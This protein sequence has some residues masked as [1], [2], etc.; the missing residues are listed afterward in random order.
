MKSAIVDAA[1]VGS[2]AALAL[3]V[4]SCSGVVSN[5]PQE[6][7]TTDNVVFM[8]EKEQSQGGADALISGRMDLARRCLTVFLEPSGT[9]S[10]IWP[11]GYSYRESSGAVSVVD[12]KGQV[13]ATTGDSLG[14]GG[15][16]IPTLSEEDFGAL[17]N[18]G[19]QS[20][21]SSPYWLISGS[22]SAASR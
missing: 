7:P 4:A 10:L 22:P 1:R 21:C 8:V 3:F 2:M 14:F 12:D 19:S 15:G 6:T 11:Y 16:E 18:G 20:D 17:F 13:V 9:Y 5:G